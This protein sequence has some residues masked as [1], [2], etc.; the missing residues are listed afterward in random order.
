MLDIMHALSGMAALISGGGRGIGQ[1]I[2]LAFAREGARVAVGARTLDQVQAVANEC[3][4]LGAN[5][6]GLHLDVSTDAS[7][8]EAVRRVEESWGGI[9]IL[10]NTAGFARSSKFLDIDDELWQHTLAVDL[11]GAFFLTR[12]ALPAM[13][14]RGDGAVIAIASIAGKIG[15]PYIAPY[16]VA[17]HGL[18]GLVRALA[19]EYPRSGVTFNAVCPAFVDTPLTEQSIAKIV[20][21]TGRPREAA[22][23][24]LFTPQGRL[25]RP[26]EVAAVCVL[27]ARRA[28]RGINGQAI[29][30]DGGTVQS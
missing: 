22:R 18:I 19:S 4:A 14:S 17:K 13:L 23:E 10:V 12:A 2:A 20:E 25:V 24:A 3:R 8:R 30:V 21:R 5:A 1:A 29:N 26:D 27:L 15:G 6:L 16:T 7:C 11:T 9:D 28:G